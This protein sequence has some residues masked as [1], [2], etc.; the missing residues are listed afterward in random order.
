MSTPPPGADGGVDILA[1]TDPLG[2]QGPRIKVQVKRTEGKVDLDKVKSFT[3]VLGPSD[4]GIYVALGGFTKAADDYARQLESKRMMLLD[5]GDLFRLWV[6]H[7]EAIP[8]ERRNLLPL[9]PVY[10][11]AT[12]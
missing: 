9:R 1:Y 8:E 4:V 3:A 2:T 7:Y 6:E 11:L 5:I 10:Y 12:T